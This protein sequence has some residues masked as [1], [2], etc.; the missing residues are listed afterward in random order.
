MLCTEEALIFLSPLAAYS[1]KKTVFPVALLYGCRNIRE[2]EGGLCM[3]NNMVLKKICGT[4]RREV[5]GNFWTVQVLV[6]IL[7][8]G[9]LYMM[10]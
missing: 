9:S 6:F 4:K 1:I 2:D 8:Q 7:G 5:T 3:F 10:E